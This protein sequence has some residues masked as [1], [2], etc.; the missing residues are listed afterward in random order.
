MFFTATGNA[1]DMWMMETLTFSRS[2][3]SLNVFRVNYK[4]CCPIPL[5]Q[6]KLRTQPEG[7]WTSGEGYA[8]RLILFRYVRPLTNNSLITNVIP[9]DFRRKWY[10]C[11]II[12]DNKM[13]VIS[14]LLTSIQ[15]ILV[16]E[17]V[18]IK[19]ASPKDN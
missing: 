5:N 3:W 14:F 18:Q 4:V 11:Y 7:Q 17:S 1:S 6:W 13:Y 8:I 16:R 2:I 12:N 15:A 9:S 10:F 19:L